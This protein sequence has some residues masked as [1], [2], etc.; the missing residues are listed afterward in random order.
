MDFLLGLLGLVILLVVLTF[1]IIAIVA[2]VKS[3][4]ARPEVQQ[5]ARARGS[6]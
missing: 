6:P 4:D 2:L 1:P 3:L 5:L